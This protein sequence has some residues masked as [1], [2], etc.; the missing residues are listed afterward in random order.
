MHRLALAHIQVKQER[1]QVISSIEEAGKELWRSGAVANW[2]AEADRQ[3][4]AV[5]RTVNGPLLEYLAGVRSLVALACAALF[6]I[7]QAINYEDAACIQFSEIS[8]RVM[9]QEVQDTQY[10]ISV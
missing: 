10:H 7:C 4:A 9:I 8:H 5:S 2:Y 3:V 6:C 1:E